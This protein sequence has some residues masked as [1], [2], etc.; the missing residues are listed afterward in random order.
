MTRVVPLLLGVLLARPAWAV[1]LQAHLDPYQVRVGETADLSVQAQGAQDLPAPQITAPDGVTVRYVGPE[2]QVSLTNGHMTAS[3]THHFS[4]V[5][6]RAGAFTIG[7]ISV[8]YQGGTLTA[9][10]V[11]LQALAANVPAGGGGAAGTDQLKLVLSTPRTEVFLHEALPLTIQLRVGN[12]QVSDLQ[13]PT[14]PGEG[15]ALE[16]LGEPGQQQQQTAQGTIQVVTFHSTLTPLKTGPLVLGP[17]HMGMALVTRRRSRSPFGGFFGDDLRSQPLDLQSD[18]ITLNVLPLP[19][20][21]RPPGFTGAV[22]QFDFDLAA[23]PKDVAV[24]DPITVTLTL[25]GTGNLESVTPPVYV[26]S[27]ALKV[28]P[29]QAPGKTGDRVFEQVVIPQQ[30]GATALPALAFSWFDPAARAYRTVT[31]GPVPITVRPSAAA[32]GTPQI[33]GTRPEQPK[34]AETL[35]RDIV[36]IKDAAGPF[37]PIGDRAWRHWSFWAW[38][39]IPLA[40]WLAAV[41]YERRRRRV[42]GDVRYARFTRAG[43]EAQRALAAARA[44][45]EAGD[46]AA[47]YDRVARAVSEYLAAKLDLPPGS[48]T[49][50]TA[51]ARLAAHGVAPALADE[52]EQ[53]FATCERVRFAPTALA[54]GDMPRTLERAGAI[55]RALERTR[56]IGAPLAALVLTAALAAVAHAAA[57]E[58]AA[59][60]FFRGNALYGEERYADAI[61]EY[62]KVL[63][64]GQESGNLYFNLGNAYLRTGDV[65]RAVLA[66]ERARRLIPGDPDLRAN[67]AFARTLSGDPDERPLWVRALFPLADRLTAS[68]LLADASALFAVTMFLL[69]ATHLFAGVRWARTAAAVA[70]VGLVVLLASGLYRLATLEVPAHAVVVAKQPATVRFE[71]SPNGTSHFEARPGAVLR[72]LGEREGWAQVARADGRR[73]W[74][75]RDAIAPL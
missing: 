30:A 68:A 65:G 27:D 62:E 66:Y 64:T 52:L 29:V 44:A 22:G 33:V 28:Y 23:A 75:Q 4:L 61:T 39:W 17:A 35:G 3:I 45:L 63:A 31:R 60:I 74:I 69:A 49:A 71:P 1:T 7:P 67:L 70:G 20:E 36:F 9:A 24:G 48:V 41:W 5:P 40:G 72:L 53:F 37:T 25:R 2:T 15:F 8:P 10:A 46:R 38:Q 42:S 6:T 58:G 56:R 12:V 32:Q 18:P 21:G 73:G 57:P 43:R 54:D 14:L 55:V 13:Y 51:R 11:T 26:E 59:T 19:D 16:K 50:E 47:F 34:A